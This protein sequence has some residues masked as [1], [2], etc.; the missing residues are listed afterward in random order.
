VCY[1]KIMSE[2]A[3]VISVMTA[4]YYATQFILVNTETVATKYSIQQKTN[5]YRSS[6]KL[7]M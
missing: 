7:H 6:L 2:L 1:S 3:S 5:E 4:L